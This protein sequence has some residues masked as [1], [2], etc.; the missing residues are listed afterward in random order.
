MHVFFLRERVDGSKKISF[1]NCKLNFVFHFGGKEGKVKAM[2]TLA[3]ANSC[4]LQWLLCSWKGTRGYWH[5]K[6]NECTSKLNTSKSSSV[7]SSSYLS[8]VVIVDAYCTLRTY[9]GHVS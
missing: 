6:K 2:H 4:R 3:L 9:V 7:F 1:V 5:L 8:F